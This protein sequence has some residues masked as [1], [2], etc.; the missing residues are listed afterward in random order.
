MKIRFS[1]LLF[2]L[3]MCCIT[4]QQVFP[5]TIQGDQIEFCENTPENEGHD[6]KSKKE[7]FNEWKNFRDGAF[8][9]V[10]GSLR[11]LTY[12]NDPAADS[13]TIPDSAYR[14]IFSPPPNKG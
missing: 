5:L 9:E 11:L 13:E 2:Y 10:V 4:F 7:S 3:L 12:S 1:I 8:A 14:S 6:S